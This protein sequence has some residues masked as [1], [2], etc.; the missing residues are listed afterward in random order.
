M[1]RFKAGIALTLVL[2]LIFVAGC[3]S[4][5]GLDVNKVLTD[6]LSVKSG[7]SKQSLKLEIVPSDGKL[8]Q[9]D[10]KMIDL[11]NSISLTI[12]SAKVQDPSNVSL[13][14][15]LN[16][17]KK[18]LPFHISIDEKEML[19]W[20]DGAKK[21]ISI[22]LSAAQAAGAG[23][24]TKISNE[25][26]IKAVTD[27]YGFIFKH[28]PNPETISVSSVTDSVYGESLPLTKLHV[29]IRGD[30]LV[31]L[32]KTFLTSVS[33]DEQGLKE[34]IN[35]LYDVYYPVYEELNAELG[36]AN[37]GFGTEESVMKDK[38][39]ATLY[40]YN[41]LKEAL[42]KL[43][44]DY[45][46]DVNQLFEQSPELKEVLSKETVLKLDIFVDSKLRV[47]KQN[48]DLNIQLPKVDGL[49]I[50]QIKVH[51]ASENWN[52]NEPVTIDK[53][54]TKNGVFAV[55]EN[56]MDSI[57][58]IKILNNFDRNS[59]SY[60]MLREDMKLGQQFIVLD[61]PQSKNV[62]SSTPSPKLMN[63]TTFVP[64]RYVSEQL[65][66][67]VSWNAKTKEVTIVDDLTG[68][69]IVLKSGSKQGLVNNAVHKMTQPVTII[70]GS[71]YVPIRFVAES[72]EATVNFNRE[73]GIITIE[74]H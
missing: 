74:R 52:V 11:L 17:E 66:A 29:E 40:F 28:A 13:K 14:G 57:N 67:N 69:K 72:L 50:K 30:E 65:E 23:L 10:Q 7:E 27:L 31:G 34:L 37:S 12:D 61:I 38:E 46:K 59:E 16:I 41:Q 68:S 55:N 45:D 19:F 70:K 56:T 44:A 53:V 39:T 18:A 47:R 2:L 58:G 54:D 25:N 63:N 15:T 8:S 71:T 42:D 26:A 22:D 49:P 6:N 48:M 21:P 9:E 36:D 60:H 3:Q 24:N 4:V 5:G 35:T 1:R 62:N 73:E 32:V 64:L 33:K 43:L 20:V 51:S